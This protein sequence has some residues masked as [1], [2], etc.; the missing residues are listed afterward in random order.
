MPTGTTQALQVRLAAPPVVPDS[1]QAQLDMLRDP[2][3]FDYMVSSCLRRLDINL[4][5]H[6]VRRDACIEQLAGYR[7]RIASGDYAPGSA[8]AGAVEA[9]IKA[10]LKKLR[11][12]MKHFLYYSY[13]NLASIRV[14]SH[15]GGQFSGMSE[16]RRFLID[17]LDFFKDR[18]VGGD[19][20]PLADLT[21]LPFPA[22][23]LTVLR[24]KAHDV[25]DLEKGRIA[26]ELALSAGYEADVDPDVEPDV[27]PT[28]DVVA[29]AA[30]GVDPDA[31]AD[32]ADH[33]PASSGLL[34]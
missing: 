28:P 21:G 3:I 13:E 14:N 15:S 7:T 2:I 27:D 19:Y 24:D 4:D 9:K 18:L 33:D 10:Q 17:H 22:W 20:I 1:A 31:S 6:E 8:L 16:L 34:P 29:D 26:S 5:D 30:P 25:I 23:A 32:P 11:A 12:S